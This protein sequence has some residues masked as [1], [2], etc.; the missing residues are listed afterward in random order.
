MRVDFDDVRTEDDLRVTYQG[1][2]FTGEVV[3]RGPDGVIV[4]LTTYYAG[5]EDGPTAEWYPTGER[6]AEGVVR[7]G[8]AVGTHRTWHRNG[9]IATHEEFDDEG[10]LLLRRCWDESGGVQPVH[11]ARRLPRKDSSA[12]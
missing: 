6:R 1:R 11:P 7:Y 3:E 4:A 10:R 12:G 5:M 2:L 9:T 8:T